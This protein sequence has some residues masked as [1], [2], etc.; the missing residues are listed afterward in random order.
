MRTYECK[1]KHILHF[2]ANRAWHINPTDTNKGKKIHTTYPFPQIASKS[3]I[4]WEGVCKSCIEVQDFE[5][6]FSLDDVEITV[7]QCSDIG[8]RVSKG[9][10]LPEDV[11]KYITFPWKIV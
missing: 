1:M 11:S 9:G 7:C 10:F 4:P 8:T 2:S 5:Q 6:G 3:E